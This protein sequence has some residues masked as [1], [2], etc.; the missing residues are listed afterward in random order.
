MAV[1]QSGAVFTWGY[2]N[3]G[4]LGHGT[5]FVNLFFIVFTRARDGISCWGGLLTHTHPLTHINRENQSTPLRV[6]TLRRETVKE[7]DVGLY[8][9]IL[10]TSSDKVS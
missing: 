9:V 5:R 4:S 6:H 3:Y 7:I 2:G 1:T 8:H 10:A